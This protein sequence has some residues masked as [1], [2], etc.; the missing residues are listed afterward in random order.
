MTPAEAVLLV[1]V[2]VVSIA[3]VLG[4]RHAYYVELRKGVKLQKRYDM[5]DERFHWY[6]ERYAVEV[7]RVLFEAPTPHEPR[8]NAAMRGVMRAAAMRFDK[9]REEYEKDFPAREHELASLKTEDLK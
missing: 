1:M 9:W 8:S 3:F 5:L 4:F 6:R 7:L 2:A